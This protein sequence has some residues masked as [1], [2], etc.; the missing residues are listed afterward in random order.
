MA[1]TSSTSPVSPRPGP[2]TTSTG[3]FADRTVTTTTAEGVRPDT[4]TRFIHKKTPGLYKRRAVVENKDRKHSDVIAAKLNDIE[5]NQGLKRAR[6]II[7]LADNVILTK[8]KEHRL[9]D[10]TVKKI[11]GLVFSSLEDS[12]WQARMDALY[13]L[14]SLRYRHYLDKPEFANL[15][16]DIASKLKDRSENNSKVIENFEKL[17]DNLSLLE[18]SSIPSGDKPS[19]KSATVSLAEADHIH[20]LEEALKESKAK[21][22]E[23][24]EL[25]KRNRNL[26]GQVTMNQKANNE[27]HQEIEQ[28]KEELKITRKEKRQL[29]SKLSTEEGAVELHFNELTNTQQENERLQ[30]ELETL[31]KQH[32]DD[33]TAITRLKEAHE[34][35]IQ[36]HE[37][38]TEHTQALLKQI[39]QLEQATELE[40]Q[41]AKRTNPTKEEEQALKLIFDA[42]SE[43][44]EATYELLFN[45][46]VSAFYH[47]T[48]GLGTG[49]KDSTI[50]LQLHKVAIQALLMQGGSEVSIQREAQEALK[51]YG[52]SKNEDDIKLLQEIKDLAQIK[53]DQTETQTI[54]GAEEKLVNKA[55]AYLEQAK[56]YLL[57]MDYRNA[58][59][60]ALKGTE[61]KC[62]NSTI[63]LDLYL[64]LIKATLKYGQPTAASLVEK[65][66]KAILKQYSNENPGLEKRIETLKT[67]VQ[68][69]TFL[70]KKEYAEVNETASVVLH[71]PCDDDVINLRLYKVLIDAALE[72]T[73]L[74]S[75]RAYVRQAINNCPHGDQ[76]LLR[77]IRRIQADLGEDI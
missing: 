33:E 36:E 64:V 5:N 71:E 44:R 48:L 18:D 12:H 23:A 42:K 52:T 56:A 35:L 73:H 62:N 41:L 32:Q 9:D 26:E 21:L 31:K 22:E 14:D 49:C 57:K 6:A 4:T 43:L 68:A 16:D 30:K 39:S 46:A 59:L 2:T 69:T 66:T 61:Q 58:Y 77:E 7:D 60:S 50:N 76:E 24:K 74:D 72:Q 40:K 10:E 75:A 70:S 63:N 55:K 51:K 20:K 47:T 65:F 27:L 45:N 11:V 3:K 17:Y 37:I 29:I 8:G 25:E 28:L 53:L 13:L 67:L 38:L 15:G 34:K 1:E 19:K 54:T